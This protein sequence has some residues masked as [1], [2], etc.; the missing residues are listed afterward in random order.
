[1]RMLINEKKIVKFLF[2][3]FNFTDAD[4]D[5]LYLTHNFLFDTIFDLSSLS[6]TRENL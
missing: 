6:F 4:R 2:E 3:S 1:M 5:L